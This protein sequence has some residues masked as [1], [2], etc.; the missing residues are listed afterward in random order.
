MIEIYSHSKHFEL[1]KSWN[2]ARC[3]F[4]LEPWMLPDLGFVAD[5]RAM[6]FL[7]TTNSPVAWFANWT[8]DPEAT[9][10]ERVYL[11]TDLIEE[12]EKVS[13]EKGFRLTQTLGKV[14]HG[15]EEILK[16]NGYIAAKGEYSFFVKEI[17]S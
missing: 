2:D 10:S 16:I 15:I 5:N 13:R 14:G 7:V 9:K 12:L 4:G 6:A 11:I 3:Q 8:V 17:R 1:M